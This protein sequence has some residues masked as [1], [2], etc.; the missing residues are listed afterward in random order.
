MTLPQLPLLD[1]IWD[2]PLGKEHAEVWS[3]PRDARNVTDPWGWHRY[4]TWT[5]RLSHQTSNLSCP[6]NLLPKGCDPCFAQYQVQGEK[7][8]IYP[9]TI[10]QLKSHNWGF[11]RR[12][13]VHAY[14]QTSHT[15][16]S[17]YVLLHEGHQDSWSRG[18]VAYWSML[19]FSGT[20]HW[21]CWLVNK[22]EHLVPE[23][24]DDSPEVQ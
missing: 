23:Y 8:V 18:S 1:Q 21:F 22:P 13:W 5:G 2:S 4:T 17:G 20:E 14:S 9:A 16:H 19:I 12:V 6:H 11:S 7:V 3:P 24:P 10:K 15:I